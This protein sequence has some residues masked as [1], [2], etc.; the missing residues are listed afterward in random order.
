MCRP[1]RVSG[2]A[3]TTLPTRAA[4]F[5]SR[6]I[7]SSDVTIVPLAQFAICNSQFSICTFPSMLGV[8][9]VVADARLSHQRHV[10]FNCMLHLTLQSL[11]NFV[12]FVGRT[13]DQ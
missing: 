8:H 7:N 3:S 5:I 13:L 10:D 9:P 4:K 2:K 6:S 11:G 12:S 1:I